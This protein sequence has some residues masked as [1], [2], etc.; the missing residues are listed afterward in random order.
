MLAVR[1]AHGVADA[2]RL[3]VAEIRRHVTQAAELRLEIQDGQA[4]VGGSLGD[5][6]NA[7][8]A[9]N[10][11]DVGEL[12]DASAVAAIESKAQRVHEQPFHGGV[13]KIDVVVVDVL[14]A[15]QPRE[16]I[17][18]GVAEVVEH[19][20]SV[21]ALRPVRVLFPLSLLLL[22]LYLPLLAATAWSRRIGAEAVIEANER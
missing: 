21:D 11:I 15:A 22:A 7:Q 9:F 13:S 10:I 17:Q 2:Q 8:L 19:E 1:K 14:F 4:I 6:G 18:H 3:V 16:R 12:V 5:A 20:A